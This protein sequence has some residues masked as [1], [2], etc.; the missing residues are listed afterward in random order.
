MHGGLVGVNKGTRL[1]VLIKAHGWYT[2]G[3]DKAT[4]LVSIKVHGGRV[5]VNKSLSIS[6]K[7]P[8]GHI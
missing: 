3:V 2:V 7:W 8:G 5:G 6:L 1:L 4:L